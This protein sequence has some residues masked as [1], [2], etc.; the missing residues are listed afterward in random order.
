[1]KI[2]DYSG[3]NVDGVQETGGLNPRR[4]DDKSM[5][6]SQSDI[7]TPDSTDLSSVTKI[8][9]RAS[10][11]DA[12]RVEELHRQVANGTY[13]VDSA[14]LAKKLVESMSDEV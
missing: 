11:R 5:V 10:E 13:Q 8:L 2:P 12:A 4:V 3:S 7:Q 6:D 1:M 14:E 9:A